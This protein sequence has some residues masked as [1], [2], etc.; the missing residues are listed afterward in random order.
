MKIVSVVGARPNFMKIAP[1]VKEFKR[2]P[3][4]SH[5]LVH[6]GQHYD[7]AMSKLFF[8]EL[9]IPR[10]DINL[11]VGSASHAKQT[12]EIMLRFEKVVQKLRPNVVIV[13][14]DVNSTMAAALVSVKMGIPVAH[15][16]A[17]LRSFDRTMPEE[18]NRLVT[19]SVSDILFTTCRDANE[20]LKKEGIA[21]GK[22]HF[23]G[24]VM[25]DTLFQ[26]M[27]KARQASPAIQ[28][29][30]N[31]YF[32]VTLHRPSNVDNPKVFRQ[33]L[34]ALS[35]VQKD[36]PIIFPMHPRTKKNFQRIIPKKR[37]QS[38]PNLQITP[39]LGYFEFLTLMINAKGVITDSGGI[40]EETT[41]LSIPCLTVRNNTERPV[42]I[43]EGSN[44][45][46]GTNTQRL[47]RECKK[48][49]KGKGKRGGRPKFWD[50]KASRRIVK[51]LILLHKKG[52]I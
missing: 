40:Q 12:A 30:R 39:P 18:I 9:G 5:T 4:I 19:D 3:S 29:K 14:G 1:L 10:P 2:Y 33:I 49:L 15:V 8:H 47:I 37:L 41:V 24:N 22:I 27:K 38:L 20:N 50:G 16:E 42:T 46:V 34:T 43:F 32:L 21:Q 13:V 11:E 31:R 25:I 36:I 6:T 7:H 28:V 52:V 23:V 44:T 48:I 45:L 51:T 26:H 17:G 35:E